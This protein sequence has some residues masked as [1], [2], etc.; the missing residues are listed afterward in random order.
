RCPAVSRARCTPGTGCHGSI[1]AKTA[2]SRSTTTHRSPRASSRSMCTA[3]R[4]RRSA[5]SAVPAA[6]LCT[7]SHGARRW[8]RRASRATRAICCDRTVTSRSRSATATTRRH[9][10][11]I[12]TTGGSPR[13]AD[14]LSRALFPEG[15]PHHGARWLAPRNL[16]EAR[17]IVYRLRT[18]PRVLVARALRLVHRISLEQHRAVLARIVGRMREHRFGDVRAARL[19]R[20]VEA[21]D[22][23]HR[24]VVDG[25]HDGRFGELR[26]IGART[27]RYPRDRLAVAIANEPRDDARVDERL[28]RRAVEIGDRYAGRN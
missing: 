21:D 1:F 5:R 12:S 22:R 2:R 19:G 20:R 26:V 27:E 28:Q 25:A 9:S 7:R 4:S 6:S 16:V 8:P 3:A 11:V 15:F 23:P 13:E 17:A 18:E 24:L 14:P 10:R